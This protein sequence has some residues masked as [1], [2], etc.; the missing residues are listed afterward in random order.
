MSCLK[1]CGSTKAVLF[2]AKG[3]TI[4]YSGI[5]NSPSIAMTSFCSDKLLQILNSEEKAEVADA[6]TLLESKQYPL[7]IFCSG[8]TSTAVINSERKGR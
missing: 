8:A 4:R 6:M 3:Y 5:G 7:F 1:C 2:F